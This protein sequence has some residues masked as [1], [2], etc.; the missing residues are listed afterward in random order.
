MGLAELSGFEETGGME[1]KATLARST[2][3]NPSWADAEQ[4]LLGA[5]EYLA[6]MPG[7]R[8]STWWG[9]SW[10]TVLRIEQSDY[11]DRPSPRVKVGRKE[12]A[13]VE[14]MLTGPDAAFTAIAPEDRPVV[15]TVLRAKLWPEGFG[16]FGWEAVRADLGVRGWRLPNGVLPAPE[17][18]RMR[19]RRAVAKV[20]ERMGGR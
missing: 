1:P 9:S 16:G 17:A 20:A 8:W 14:A 2:N 19:Y 5:V 3:K 15:A 11:P 13:L 7:E 4:A 6:A 10:P 12:V 18:L